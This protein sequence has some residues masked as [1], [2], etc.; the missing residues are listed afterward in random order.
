MTSGESLANHWI[1]SKSHHHHTINT[2]NAPSNADPVFSL[3]IRIHPSPFLSGPI[4]FPSLT[5]LETTA[6]I[7]MVVATI[8]LLPLARGLVLRSLVRDGEAVMEP[9]GNMR[10]ITP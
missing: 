6:I 9:T 1:F 3:Y 10:N 2:L 4:L 8:A 7:T 5:G